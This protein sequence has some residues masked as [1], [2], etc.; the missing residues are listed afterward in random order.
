[1]AQL[2]RRSTLIHEVLGSNL[3]LVILSVLPKLGGLMTASEPVL[4]CTGGVKSSN[5]VGLAPGEV[6][7][8]QLLERPLHPGHRVLLLS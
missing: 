5:L 2:V 4:G 3:A 1:M 7:Q 8:C 6:P